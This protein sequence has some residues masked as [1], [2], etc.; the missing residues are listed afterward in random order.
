LLDAEGRGLE[1]LPFFMEVEMAKEPNKVE[2]TKEV[3]RTKEVKRTVSVAPNP[4]QPRYY[5]GVF[6]APSET[7]AQYP[8]PKPGEPVN[9][10]SGPNKSTLKK[11][12]ESK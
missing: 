5:E 1:P 6:R 7:P 4:I 2:I 12:V 3:A 8:V 10:E 11:K 9:P